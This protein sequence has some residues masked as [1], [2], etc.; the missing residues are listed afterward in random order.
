MNIAL[1]ILTK[2]YT[3][4]G[5]RIC[6]LCLAC[7]TIVFEST[8]AY[9][10]YRHGMCLWDG[11]PCAIKYEQFKCTNLRKCAQLSVNSIF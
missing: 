6:S 7:I 5:E 4:L 10:Y 8:I 9:Y 3:I 1:V 2:V 11:W